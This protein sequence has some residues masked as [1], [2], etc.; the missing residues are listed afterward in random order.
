VETVEKYEIRNTKFETNP[1]HEIQMIETLSR[2]A[3]SVL[4]FEFWSFE[5]VLDFEIRISDLVSSGRS[6]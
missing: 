5:F 2:L 4:D 6:E 3:R 1:K